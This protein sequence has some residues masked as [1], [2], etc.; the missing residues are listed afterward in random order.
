MDRHHWRVRIA[1]LHAERDATEIYRILAFH[2]FPWDYE[3]SLGL[4]L[5]RTFAV[6][7]IGSL[8]ARTGEFTARTQKRYDDTAILLQ[9]MLRHGPQGGDGRVA[10]R[11]MNRMHGAYPISDEDYRYVL[12]TF[13]V[14]PARWIQ[15]FGWRTLTD[16]ELAATTHYFH[17]MGRLMG[18]PAIPRSY[19]EFEAL[20][21][22]E[23]R[24]RFAPDPG[25][26][27][28]ADATLDLMASWYPRPARRLVRSASIALL[29]DHLI[30]ALEYPTPSPALR[31]AVIVALR[32]RARVVRLLPA[33]RR[34]RLPSESR[35]VRGY[36][37]GYD[38]AGL[39]T[40]PS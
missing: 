15:R 17:R 12:A 31:R 18:I 11:R 28:V 30:A 14:T 16:H 29:D 2:E 10:L 34:P 4:A 32:F 25:G 21:D 24:R 3:Q 23:E 8:L 6:P 5:F 19:A 35:R 7:S 40:F 38:V 20:L 9:E 33:R 37:R 27:A 39:G 1:D 22:G 36:P 13:V 26:R